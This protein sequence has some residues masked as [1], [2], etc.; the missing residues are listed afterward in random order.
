MNTN[1]KPGTIS[2]IPGDIDI[3][4]RNTP[5]VQTRSA[6]VTR[7]V[8]TLEREAPR[9]M[10]LGRSVN[11]NVNYLGIAPMFNK[12]LMFA[13]DETDWIVGPIGGTEMPVVPKEQRK[14]LE[15]LEAV[16]AHFPILYVA[17][18]VKKGNFPGSL[19]AP[20][21]SVATIPMEQVGEIVGP[22]PV[23]A[24]S[25]ET[26]ARL[27]LRTNQVFRAI[28]R[29]GAVAGAVAGALAAA[30]LLLVGSA[31]SALSTLDPIVFGVIP[32]LLAETDEPAA[33]YV[34]AR[35]DW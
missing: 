8:A 4:L 12:T 21:G 32:A 7:R 35:W 22:T 13:G 27:N 30:P 9:I 19:N 17:H 33:W 16:G 6:M 26:A 23:P 24:G 3:L 5:N 20:S 1:S 31:V 29:V 34:L 11:A 25:V 10:T 15:R 28:G 14:S 18:E 2:A